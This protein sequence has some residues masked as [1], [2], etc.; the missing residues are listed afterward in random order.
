MIEFFQ[1]LLG[2]EET[3]STARE[4]LRLVLIHDRSSIT[5]GLMDDLKADLLDVINRYME[6]DSDNMEL[7]LERQDG[8]VALAASIPVIQIRRTPLRPTQYEEKSSK[9]VETAAEKPREPEK[10]GKIT[11]KTTTSTRSRRRRA[12]KTAPTI[13]R[14][15]V[16]KPSSKRKKSKS[17]IKR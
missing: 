16:K 11:T 1:R 7:M 15:R 6:I 8:S 9:K 10:P 3:R 12:T 4:R 2:K 13:A 5:P 17:K 14:K